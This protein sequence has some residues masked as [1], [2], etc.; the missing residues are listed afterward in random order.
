MH[1]TLSSFSVAVED[2]IETS[3]GS[4]PELNPRK[5]NSL[6]DIVSTDQKDAKRGIVLQDPVISQSLTL[7]AFQQLPGSVG[8]HSFLAGMHCA[9]SRT[10]MRIATITELTE[11][12]PSNHVLHLLG[13]C[14]LYM[15]RATDTFPLEIAPMQK[16]KEIRFHSRDL[17][18]C[19][20]CKSR[21]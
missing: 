9:Y 1:T 19:V 21:T 13:A 12:K 3:L 15:S 7:S 8:I 4:M 17:E 11:R 5:P 20:G 18:T 6:D 16:T 14:N 10:T 2:S